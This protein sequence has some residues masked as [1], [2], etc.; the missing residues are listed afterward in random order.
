MAGDTGHPRSKTR[1]TFG[2]IAQIGG[3]Q[4]TPYRRF[5]TFDPVRQPVAFSVANRV[6]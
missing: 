6:V 3:S 5:G 1:T 4:S 2:S